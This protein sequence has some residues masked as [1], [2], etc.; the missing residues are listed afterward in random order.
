MP[1]A[2]SKSSSKFKKIL[3]RIFLTILGLAFILWGLSTVSLG[4]FG[5]KST[6]L[7]TNVRR[8]G[9]ERNEAIRGRYTY[10]ISYT[11]TLPDGKS[12][13][14]FTKRVGNSVFMKPDGKS[15]RAVRYFEFFP[16]I[17]ALE[18]DT[19]PGLGQLIL[20]AIGCFFIYIINRKEKN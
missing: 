8:E 6:A 12:V 15:K 20:V 9:G 19:K 1:K 3:T 11:F 5:K 2:K 13:D 14:G 10:V 4:F 17:N 7:I 18:E 16:Y